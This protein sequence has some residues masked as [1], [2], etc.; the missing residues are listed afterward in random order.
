LFHVF[1]DALGRL[2]RHRE[3]EGASFARLRLK[4]YPAPVSFHDAPAN[5]KSYAC[6]W[7]FLQLRKTLE[8]LENALVIRRRNTD[9]IVLDGKTPAMVPP[10]R[11]NLDLRRLRRAGLQ[12]IADQ[13]LK[14]ADNLP[15]IG[16]QD[17][18]LIAQQGA[19]CLLELG[20][21]ARCRLIDGDREVHQLKPT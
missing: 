19:A 5:G 7:Q 10:C 17:R 11:R 20:L 15:A 14:Q 16:P 9:P 3:K 4:P 12:A 6:T 2:A 18:K 8:Q 21:E 13:I 1:A